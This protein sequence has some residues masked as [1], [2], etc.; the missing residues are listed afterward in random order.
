MYCPPLCDRHARVRSATPP[1]RG[2]AS[3]FISVA[4]RV[5]SPAI[6]KLVAQAL[7]YQ[8]NPVMLCLDVM[9]R[10]LPLKN[11]D[12]GFRGAGDDKLFS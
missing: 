10:E 4:L 3:P 5:R 2:E 7:A 6:S 12:N 11:D 8:A 1:R 9:Q